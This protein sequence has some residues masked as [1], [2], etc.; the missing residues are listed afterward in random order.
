MMSISGTGNIQGQSGQTAPDMN[1]A[2]DSVSKSIQNQI[3]KV[4]KQLQELSSNENMTIEEKMKKRQELQQEITSLNQQLRQHEIELRKKQQEEASK[5]EDLTGGKR[6]EAAKKE[7]KGT[8]LSQASMHAMVSADTSMKQAKV[9]GSTATR[10]EGKANVLESEI[11]LDAQ[12]GT[13]TERKEEELAELQQKA[14]SAKDSQG[15]ILVTA[16]EE[17]Q[18]ANKTANESDQHED[19]DRS[20]EKGQRSGVYTPVDVYV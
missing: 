1:R 20:E 18:N 5:A 7:Q 14:Q 9:Q 8:G 15:S 19:P 13:A 11:K 3:A 10:L 6:T 12:R 17:M 4:Q 16:A 2:T